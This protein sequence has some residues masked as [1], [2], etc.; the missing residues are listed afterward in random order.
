MALAIMIKC[1]CKNISFEKIIEIGDGWPKAFT[2]VAYYEGATGSN[3][4]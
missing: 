2:Y 4:W 3:G 1:L